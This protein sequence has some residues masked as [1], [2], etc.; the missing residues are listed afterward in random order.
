MIPI[1]CRAVQTT[2]IGRD[3]PILYVL[4][5]EVDGKYKLTTGFA[6]NYIYGTQLQLD[7]LRVPFDEPQPN[8]PTCLLITDN[9]T[10][11]MLYHYLRD[12]RILWP[13]D[14]D[15][16]KNRVT[17][18]R[19]DAINER[20]DKRAYNIK[21]HIANQLVPD[22]LEI[23]TNKTNLPHSP[24]KHLVPTSIKLPHPK[25]PEF[26]KCMSRALAEMRSGVI[27]LLKPAGV[28]CCRG[29]GIHIIS[30]ISELESTV[31]K[32]LSENKRYDYVLNK[33][34]M[35]PL[36]WFGKKFHSRG[37]VALTTHKSRAAVCTEFGLMHARDKYVASDWQNKNIH[38]SH[39]ATTIGLIIV[40]AHGAAYD[41]EV[42]MELL[43]KRSMEIMNEIKKSIVNSE[44]EIIAYPESNHAYEVF[45]VDLMFDVD[46]NPYLI[47]FNRKPGWEEDE[48]A[49]DHKYLLGHLK[50]YVRW[51]YTECIKPFLTN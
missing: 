6:L 12:W 40:P 27:W 26:K 30:E 50:N 8:A 1:H 32:V 2:K 23:L 19:I 46:Y 15:N 21:S 47:E 28:R 20:L 34:I 10:R 3:E 7:F 33:Y 14:I 17:L 18:L 29:I 43:H 51:E 24:L 42:D 31:V 9:S 45:G 16:I 38:D 36:L 22:T 11:Q 44:I 5:P 48:V 49:T 25:S 13:R 4:I 35:N 39:A 41:P 37:Y